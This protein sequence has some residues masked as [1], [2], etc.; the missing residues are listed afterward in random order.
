[1]CVGRTIIAKAISSVRRYGSLCTCVCLIGLWVRSTYRWDLVIWEH[2]T[3]S[4][5]IRSMDQKLNFRLRR[6]GETEGFTNWIGFRPVDDRNYDLPE[7][8]DG[9]PYHEII[10]GFPWDEL[11]KDMLFWDT[12]T[13]ELPLGF[14]Y[15]SAVSS[16]WTESAGTFSAISV[17]YWC[18]T[19]LVATGPVAS[20]IRWRRKRSRR[21][22]GLC[23]RCGYDLRF[24]PDQCPECGTM[25]T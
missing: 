1:M 14:E 20:L 11:F 17:P 6:G 12:A 7:K 9:I 3:G 4:L 10:G 5:S 25:V 15:S 16:P 21:A 22:R 8:V 24:T 19:M 18:P 23:V 13:T 2:E